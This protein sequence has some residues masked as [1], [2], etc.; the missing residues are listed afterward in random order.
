MKCPKC[1]R[2]IE[3]GSLFCQYCFADIRIVPTYDS[4]VEQ[5]ISETMSQVR[6]EVD[7]ETYKEERSIQKAAEARKKE[8]KAR[9]VVTTVILTLAAVCLLLGLL[10]MKLRTSPSYYLGQA[11][12]KADQGDYGGAADLITKAQQV[13]ENTDTRL[14]LEKAEYLE[15]AGRTEEALATAKLVIAAADPASEDV[16]NA[17]GRMID[18]YSQE[19][20][21]DKISGILE[22]SGNEKVKEVYSQYL[23]FEPEIL[24]KSGDFNEGI[25]VTITTKGGGSIFY[26]IDGSIPTTDSLLYSK[27]LELSDGKY[28]IRAITVS[29]F[30]LESKVVSRKYSIGEQ[31][32]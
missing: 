32:E 5:K 19:R 28:T 9:L 7:L 11:Y 31:E 29:P 1:G 3:D 14:M 30:G 27:P 18:I 6:D 12:E 16:V 25:E 22:D 2:E 13:S 15:K 26:T 4:T 10:W 8:K 23:V 24:P 21:Y 20:D 17:Y